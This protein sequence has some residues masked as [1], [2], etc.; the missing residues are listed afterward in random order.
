MKF[1]NTYVHEDAYV[2]HMTDA[3]IL[4]DDGSIDGM[5]IPLSQIENSEDMDVGYE[6]DIVMSEWI[7]TQKGLV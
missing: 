4:I 2:K 5:W 6:G 7:A 1:I 3:A